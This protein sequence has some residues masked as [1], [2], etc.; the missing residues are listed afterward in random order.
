MN[1]SLPN[2]AQFLRH[3]LLLL[4][5]TGL[6]SS[7]LIPGLTKQWQDH[8]KAIEIRTRL[9]SEVTESVIKLLLSVQ[10]AERNAI[11]QDKYNEAYQE[12]EIKRAVLGTQLRGY[13]HDPQ[14]AV[15]WETFSEA[16]TTIYVLS[17]TWD[18]PYRSQVIKKLMSY[19]SPGATDWELLRHYELKRKS[20]QDF[21]RY[22][23]AWWNLREAT[24]LKTGDFVKRILHSR[25]STYD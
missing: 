11:Q 10:F 22:F 8:E 19:Y 23:K 17:G 5:A 16:V 4:L 20:V 6:I 25:T 12:W 21:Q 18:E 7:W 15:D 1:I 3:P 9:S 13:F 14:L 24:I 2:I